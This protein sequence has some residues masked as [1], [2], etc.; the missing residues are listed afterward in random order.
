MVTNQKN[1]DCPP[2]CS[3][4]HVHISYPDSIR[5]VAANASHCCVRFI[6]YNKCTEYATKNDALPARTKKYQIT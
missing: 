1:T 4:G 5:C 3:T 6:R 2:L